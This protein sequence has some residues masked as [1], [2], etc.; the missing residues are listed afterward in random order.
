[1]DAEI[2]QKPCIIVDSE[3]PQ[4]QHVVIL[5]RRRQLMR[6]E[7]FRFKVFPPTSG[8]QM[9]VICDIQANDFHTQI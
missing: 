7:L 4:D 6:L 9:L 5:G 8:C 2:T 1:M 3:E